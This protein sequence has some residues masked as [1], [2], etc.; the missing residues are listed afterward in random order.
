MCA[1]ELCLQEP[2]N[3]VVSP[4]HSQAVLGKHPNI[5]ECVGFATDAAGK[6]APAL[7]L[8]QAFRFVDGVVRCFVVARTSLYSLSQL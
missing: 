7:V 6:E 3:R 2:S 8:E 5:V 1:V 4:C